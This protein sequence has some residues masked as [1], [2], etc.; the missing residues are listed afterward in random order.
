[1]QHRLLILVAVPIAYS[2]VFFGWCY[3]AGK[4]PIFSER[5]LHSAPRVICAHVSVLL[6]L[7][8]LAQAAFRL[9]PA[10]PGWLTD[11]SFG[12]G[13]RHSLF[14]YLCTF[15]VLAIGYIE[16]RWVYAESGV[17]SPDSK[18]GSS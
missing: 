2:I 9:Y 5:N 7:A 18:E 10:L 13:G 4:A 14:E 12:R 17:E 1:M 16:K 3:L 11:P 6:I 8:M 15:T